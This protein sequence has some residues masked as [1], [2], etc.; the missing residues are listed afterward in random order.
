MCSNRPDKYEVLISSIYAYTI[1]IGANCTAFRAKDLSPV[2]IGPGLALLERGCKRLVPVKLC[3]TTAF[4]YTKLER[5]RS[6]LRVLYF[7]LKDAH[8]C[9]RFVHGNNE[10]VGQARAVLETNVTA[11]R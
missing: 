11:G 7:K 3:Y 1:E 10:G 9:Q 5:G 6:N 2:L 8:V 4:V